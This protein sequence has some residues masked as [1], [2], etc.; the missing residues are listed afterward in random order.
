MRV[1]RAMLT[2]KDLRNYYNEIT[3]TIPNRRH[4]VTSLTAH[5]CYS[6]YFPVIIPA[7]ICYLENLEKPRTMS[8]ASTGMSCIKK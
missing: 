4:Y 3:N 6:V 2:A 8:L 7:D 5:I 1:R